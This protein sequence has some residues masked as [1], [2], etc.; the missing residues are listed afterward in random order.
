MDE[1]CTIGRVPPSAYFRGVAVDFDGT[2]TEAG[3]PSSNVLEA[4][5]EARSAGLSLV[6]VTG[7]VASDLL[8]VF[9]DVEAHFDAIVA[10][11]GA[12][13]RRSGVSRALTAPVPFDLDAPLVAHG[14]HFDRGQVLLGCHSDSE[15]L[16]FHELR[17]LELDCQL[18]RNRD[19]LMVLPASVSKASGLSAA[20]NE[21][22][23]SRHSVVA[24][25]DA[26]NDLALLRACEVGVA[27]EN[28]VS[29]LKREA[30]VVLSIRDGEGVALF[31]RDDLLA[32]RALPTSSRWQVPIGTLK[33]GD[34]VS[35]PASQVNLL[36][37][38]GS[39]AGKS[40]AAGLIAER[41]IELGY[42]LC[43]LD[44]EGDHGPLG[45]MHN[46]VTVG[47]AG[48]LPQATD[49]PQLLKQQLGSVVV[50]L[51]LID[52]SD[53][54]AYMTSLLWALREERHRS[55]LPH[56]IVVD[57]AHMPFG[58]QANAWDPFDGEKGI[59]LVTYDAGQLLAASGLDIDFVLAL[60]G[61]DGLDPMI[62]DA[63]GPTLGDD[64]REASA[65][66]T[67]ALVRLEPTRSTVVFDIGSRFVRHVRHWHKYV[68]SGLSRGDRFCFRT[69]GGP[70]GAHAEN[71]TSFRRELLHCDPG[72]LE[73]HIAHHDFS[74]WLGAAI[75]DSTLASTIYELEERGRA[76]PPEELRHRLLKAIEDRYFA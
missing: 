67:A 68:R 28:A 35:I 38:G 13:V 18:V 61:T 76:T 70:T 75:G 54:R 44:P 65:L 41:L 14:V 7:R 20:L 21:L 37:V 43:I 2:L 32:G 3:R 74:K 19:A 12:V 59:A 66:G 57:E 36:V 72:V 62:R 16:V 4:L 31:L 5:G 50:D 48:L 45:R 46:V 69:H 34:P 47:G 9:P 64:M 56:W 29:S 49:V 17:R 30:D 26:E 1:V 52:E 58:N 53:R 42:S 33:N 27:V 71:V 15:E 40:Y 73:H 11:N 55:G 25:G 51:S 8:H 24:V 6:L 10:E 63:L 22:G 23:L 60:A 39:G